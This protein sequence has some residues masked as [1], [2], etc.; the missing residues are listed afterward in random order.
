M[1]TCGTSGASYF[2]HAC[3]HETTPIDQDKLWPQLLCSLCMSDFVEAIPVRHSGCLFTGIFPEVCQPFLRLGVHQT[4]SSQ[5]S[6]VQDE[7]Q[8]ESSSRPTACR[9]TSIGLFEAPRPP[10]RSSSPSIPERLF[11]QLFAK[12]IMRRL[13]RMLRTTLG[14]AP[15]S[16]QQMSNLT[17]FELSVS[18]AASSGQC[19]ICLEAFQPATLCIKLPCEHVYHHDCAQQWLLQHG[20]CPLCRKDLDGNVIQLSDQSDD[21]LF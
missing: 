14:P 7:A 5:V 2:C 9:S 17:T 12:N 11:V 18:E 6:R 20:L 13:H 21:D 4:I 19:V 15:A 8:R 1:A 10:I 3:G 16:K